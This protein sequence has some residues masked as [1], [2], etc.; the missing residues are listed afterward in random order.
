[1]NNGCYHVFMQDKDLHHLLFQ[2][3][4]EIEVQSEEE[5]QTAI[6]ISA[7]FRYGIY[8]DLIAGAAYNAWTADSPAEGTDTLVFGG[9]LAQ[10]FSVLRG[11]TDINNYHV[12]RGMHVNTFNLT[13]GVEDLAT[14]TFGMIGMGREAAS[15]LPSGTVTEPTLTP[16]ISGIS[17][18]DVTIDGVTQVG[19][20]IVTGKQI[21]R[22]HV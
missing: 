6:H 13:I 15:I 3:T 19:V 16:V 21:G 14:V 5:E 8:D 18:D 17:V 22:A 9:N 1:M 2:V 20:L 12:F 10:S 11:Y 4:N 7:E